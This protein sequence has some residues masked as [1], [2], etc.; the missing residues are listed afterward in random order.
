MTNDEI[1]RLITGRNAALTENVKSMIEGGIGDQ[2]WPMSIAGGIQTLNMLLAE[3]AKRLP[4]P[5]RIKLHRF[6]NDNADR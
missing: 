2:V 6:E 4:E 5:T 1:D 3:I